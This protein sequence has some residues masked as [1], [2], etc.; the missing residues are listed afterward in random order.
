[1]TQKPLTNKTTIVSLV[2]LALML[3][4]SLGTLPVSLRWYNA[5]SLDQAV[6]HPPSLTP[7]IQ[8]DSALGVEL[9]ISNAFASLL[10]HDDLGRSLLYRLMPGF[11]V[12]L[13]IGL[14][15]ALIAGVIGTLWGS[16]AAMVGGRVDLIMMR[17]VDVLYGLPYILMVIL[18][19]VALTPILSSLLGAKVASLAVLFIAIGGVSWLT[20]A[21]VVRG[22]VLSLKTQVFVDAARV[23][24][25]GPFFILRRHII[26]N[27]IGPIV[28]YGALVVPQAIMQESF[29]SFLGIG[30]QQPLPSLGRLAADGVEAVNLFVGYWWLIVFPCGVLVVTLIA[31]NFLGDALRDTFD[32]KSTVNLLV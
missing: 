8:P 24:G 6:R 12:S 22:Q 23:A 7:V 16:I 31:L 28:T 25:A 26:P 27:L 15:S 10:G 32:P 29:L 4:V 18:L 30:V 17:V 9:G 14:C 1:M 19:K 2:I 13:G 3:L 20:M 21:R 11:L 5:Q